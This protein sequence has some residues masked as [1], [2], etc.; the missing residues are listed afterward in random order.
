MKYP[1]ALEDKVK[2]IEAIIEKWPVE[3][4]LQEVMAWI[5]QFET[6]DFDL[7]IRIIKERVTWVPCHVMT[8]VRLLTTHQIIK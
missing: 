8:E 2:E 4:S 5:L 3:K 7:A 6:E 1:R